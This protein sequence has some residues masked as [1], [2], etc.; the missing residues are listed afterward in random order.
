MKL[1]AHL[2]LPMLL[3]ALLL[4]ALPAAANDEVANVDA[5]STVIKF[6]PL[7]EYEA[8]ILSVRGPKLEKFSKR[9]EAGELPYFEPVKP[10]GQAFLDGPYIFELRVLPRLDESTIAELKAARERGNEDEVHQQLCLEGRIPD[11]A[12]T[13][14]GSFRIER[15]R[16]ILGGEEEP[17]E[18][19]RVAAAASAQKSSGDPNGGLS[20]LA[21]ADF[22]IN[23]DLIVDGSACIGF[24]CVNGESFGFDTIRLKENNLRIKFD[25]TSTAAS[26]P[27]NDWQLTAN[28]SANGGASKFSI[29]DISGGRTPFTVEANAPSHSLY[30]DDGGRVGLGT[31]TPSVELHVIDG[32]TPTLRLQQDGS[33]GF[34][35]QSWDVAGNETNFFVRDVS[36]GSALP[37]R[38]RPGAPTSSVFIDVDG[39][40]GIGT[41]SPDAQLD[42]ENDGLPFGFRLSNSAAN[43]SFWDTKQSTSGYAISKDTEIAWLLIFD[44]G[45]VRLGP[46]ATATPTFL[47]QTNGDLE[48]GGTLTQNSDVNSKQGFAPVNGADVLSKIMAMPITT[49][50]FKNGDPDVRHMGPMAQDFFAAFQLGAKENKLAPVDVDG[51]SLVAIQEL[52]RRLEQKDADLQAL[53]AESDTLRAESTE[54]RQR[55]EALEALLRA[56][57]P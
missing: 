22:V 20:S 29:D 2:L 30:V 17:K 6:S 21:E 52:T 57:Q 18:S 37:F 19:T 39:D 24:D 10:S 28:D 8:I 33:S 47:L 16:I 25:D 5:N 38:I 46:G 13:Q 1:T 14:N 36:N 26:F 27:R 40:V 4:A 7:I 54:L 43:G 11:H 45:R 51:V 50:S 49:W 31:S 48:I 42:I 55:L 56:Q 41:S 12:I 32:D 53:R 23:D 35:P 15:G 3:A 34:A 44:D 9:F